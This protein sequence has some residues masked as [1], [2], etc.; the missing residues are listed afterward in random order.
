MKRPLKT[1]KE[2]R[3]AL[4]EVDRL[5]LSPEGTPE[6]DRLELLIDAV[7]AY[8]AQQYPMRGLDPV[9]HILGHMENSGRTQADLARLLGSRSRAS[10]VL[11]RKR[12]LTVEMIYKLNREWGIPA[13]LLIR[14]Y[15]VD[16]A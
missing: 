8:E 9:E 1:E 6:G 13:E 11:S 5:W 7:E 3:D 12:A 15:Q 10:E 16:A 14:P 4:R 2:Y